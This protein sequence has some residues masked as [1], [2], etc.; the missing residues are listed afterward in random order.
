[1]GDILDYLP[2]LPAWQ[3]R[4]YYIEGVMLRGALPKETMINTYGW[5]LSIA[6]I[7]TDAYGSL[8]II[9]QSPSQAATFIDMNAE[10]IRAYGALCQDPGGWV[11]KYYRPNLQ[12]TFGYYISAV[13]TA[14]FQGT[15]LPFT[16]PT[17]VTLSLPNQSTQ[18]SAYIGA[19]ATVIEL[20][21]KDQFFKALKELKH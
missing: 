5:L 1:M 10:L 6:L 13:L 7:S 16:P 2:F 15:P 14:G 11:Q 8:S 17:R 21:D 19:Y 9:P 3:Y 20:T 12:S 18:N 4:N